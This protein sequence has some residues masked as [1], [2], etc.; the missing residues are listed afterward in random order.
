[1]PKVAMNSDAATTSAE[2]TSITAIKI[3]LTCYYKKV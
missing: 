1:M 2:D 3:D